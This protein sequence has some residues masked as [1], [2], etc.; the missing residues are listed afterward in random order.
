MDVSGKI[1]NDI[2]VIEN[3][4][5]MKEFEKKWCVLIQSLHAYITST[6]EFVVHV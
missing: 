6:H 3:I 5:H 1:F 2:I 4:E